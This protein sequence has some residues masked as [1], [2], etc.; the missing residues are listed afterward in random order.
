MYVPRALVDQLWQG[1]DVGGKQFFQSPVLQNLVYDRVL[2]AY[3]FEFFLRSRILSA[4][5][6]ACL[7]VQPHFS[8]EHFAYLPGRR[9][10]E[11]VPRHFIDVFFKLLHFRAEGVARFFEGGRVDAHA[12]ALHFGEHGHKRHFDALEHI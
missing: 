3:L 11:V 4:F 6:F 10:E 5:R 12:V 8:E 1:F 9:E 2:V 7:F